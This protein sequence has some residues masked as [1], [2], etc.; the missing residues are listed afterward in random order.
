[1]PF[2][3]EVDKPLGYATKPFDFIIISKS[4]LELQAS[5]DFFFFF[6][7]KLTFAVFERC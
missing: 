2:L 1:M 5:E 6:F 4:P 7:T 3:P